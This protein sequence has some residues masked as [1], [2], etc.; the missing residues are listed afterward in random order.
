MRAGSAFIAHLL[1]PDEFTLSVQE[2][3]MGKAAMI[4]GAIPGATGFVP[5]GMSA[6]GRFTGLIYWFGHNKTSYSEVR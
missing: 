3:I 2:N 4:A 6:A 5:P 1:I